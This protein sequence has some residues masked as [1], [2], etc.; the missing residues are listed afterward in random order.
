[1]SE[2]EGFQVDVNIPKKQKSDNNNIVREPTTK[3]KNSTLKISFIEES[4]LDDT[5]NN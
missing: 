1:M 3:E 4:L 5:S 2:K